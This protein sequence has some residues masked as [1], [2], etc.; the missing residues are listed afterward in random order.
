MS[1][2]RQLNLHKPRK[3]LK[4]IST[5]GHLPNPHTNSRSVKSPKQSIS[6]SFY[7]IIQPIGSIV[8]GF[9][10]ATHE[11]QGIVRLSCDQARMMILI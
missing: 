4:N 5:I 1:Y 7:S 9:I 11:L 6:Q 10:Y 2:S 3:N 8:R